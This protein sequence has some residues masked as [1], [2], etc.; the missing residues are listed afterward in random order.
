MSELNEIPFGKEYGQFSKYCKDNYSDIILVNESELENFK[1]KLFSEGIEHGL[2]GWMS[3]MVIKQ[4][5]EKEVVIC[6][7]M[8]KK[9]NLKKETNTSNDFQDQS[10]QS[11]ENTNPIESKQSTTVKKIEGDESIDVINQYF[12]TECYYLVVDEAQSAEKVNPQFFQNSI[13][14]DKYLRSL[15]NTDLEKAVLE[16]DRVLE[17]A[18]DKTK[19]LS[20]AAS[21]FT[22]KGEKSKDVKLLKKGLECYNSHNFLDLEI[23]TKRINYVQKLISEIQFENKLNSLGISEGFLEYYKENN[24]IKIYKLSCYL[25]EPQYARDRKSIKEWKD[26]NLSFF[27]P[28]KSSITDK[29]AVAFIK[30]NWDK[31][32]LF[33]SDINWRSKGCYD[34]Y[35]L[36]SFDK[37]KMEVIEFYEIE[38]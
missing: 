12:K 20:T 22:K 3:L 18:Q 8:S 17:I 25:S 23:K 1:K 28:A 37:R 38:I 4:H 29:N 14:A 19:I 34:Y 21:I 6:P 2:P 24:Y 11:I 26:S 10:A 9:V 36:G 13:I 5:I 30:A 33:C 7:I 15:L 35:D 32:R 16:V 27:I 31:Y